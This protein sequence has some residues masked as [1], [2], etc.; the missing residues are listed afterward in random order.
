MNDFNLI[1]SN[2]HLLVGRD[3]QDNIGRRAAFQD[4]AADLPLERADGE[5]GVALVQT[6]IAGW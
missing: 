6:P 2:P 1:A 3:R 4:A 5:R